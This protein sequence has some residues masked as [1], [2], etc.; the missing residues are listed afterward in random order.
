MHYAGVATTQEIA[1]YITIFL[2]LKICRISLIFS[3]SCL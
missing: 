3:F 2:I 1:E